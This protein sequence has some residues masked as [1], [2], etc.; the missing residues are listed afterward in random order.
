MSIPKQLEES[1]IW[2]SR[3]LEFDPA[4]R[5][6]KQPNFSK[7]GDAGGIKIRDVRRSQKPIIQVGWV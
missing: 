1:G 4:K 2:Q 3:R 6:V 5:R 7:L